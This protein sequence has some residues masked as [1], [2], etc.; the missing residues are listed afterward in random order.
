M[1]SKVA[2]GIDPFILCI[3]FFMQ[4]EIVIGDT[5]FFLMVCPVALRRRPSSLFL[6]HLFSYG[7]R[8]VVVAL[9]YQMLKLHEQP[10]HSVKRWHSSPCALRFAGSTLLCKTTTDTRYARHSGRNQIVTM[11]SGREAPHRKK[12][13]VSL[14]S[15]TAVE[16]SV[17]CK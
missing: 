3:S 17:T 9:G 16:G 2:N 8:F 11:S 4:N 6:K 12:I 7:R 1:R 15:P 5:R 10:L 13:D 14:L